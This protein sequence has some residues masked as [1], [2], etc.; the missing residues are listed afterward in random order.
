MVSRANSLHQATEEEL[1]AFK[2]NDIVLVQQQRKTS[3][4]DH[5]FQGSK[6]WTGRAIIVSRSET[7][8]NHYQI[9]WISDGMVDREK[10]GSISNTLW[11]AWRMKSATRLDSDPLQAAKPTVDATRKS[12]KH[13]A[14]AS[15][16]SSTSHQEHNQEGDSRASQVQTPSSTIKD[17]ANRS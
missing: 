10:A 12:K 15:S 6:K 8:A 2:E 13:R 3:H 5:R 7:S 14:S 16:R 1:D 4:T 11:L 9:Q 17:I